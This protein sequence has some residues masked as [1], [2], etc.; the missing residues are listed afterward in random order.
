MTVSQKLAVAEAE[1]LAAEEATKCADVAHKRKAIH[2]NGRTKASR[3]TSTLCPE[4]LE[5]LMGLH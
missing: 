3:R 1:A 2:N 4:E 5:G